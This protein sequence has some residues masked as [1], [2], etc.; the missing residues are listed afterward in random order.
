M[1]TEESFA[2]VE[3][4]YMLTVPQEQFI[5]DE[6]QKQ[7]FCW[8]DFGDPTVQSLYYDTP[9]YQ[10]IRTSLDRPVYKEKLRLRAYGKPEKVTMSFIEVKKKYKGVVY[11]RRVAQPL[12]TAYIGLNSGHVSEDGGQV[13]REA[14][15][16]VHRYALQ[17]KAVITY[18]RD[19]WFS[20]RWPDVRITFDRNLAFRQSDFSLTSQ[21]PNAALT[22]PTQRLMEIK[23][24]GTVPL[25]LSRLLQAACADR[26]HFSKYGLAYLKYIQP[27]SGGAL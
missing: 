23:T 27:Q 10:L 6:L 24:G 2:R 7:G 12:E 17:P 18:D 3:T 11:K 15:W 25:W 14:E 8:M 20:E 19:A 4:K 1:M 16:M 21:S 9:G 5:E 22:T 26:V 13:A